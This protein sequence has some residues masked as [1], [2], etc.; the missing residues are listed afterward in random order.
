MRCDGS[1]KPK[2]YNQKIKFKKGALPLSL[3][4]LDQRD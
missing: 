3:E 4:N 2:S 1:S